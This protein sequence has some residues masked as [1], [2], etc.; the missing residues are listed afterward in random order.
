MRR[1][2]YCRRRDMRPDRGAQ[3]Q[4][5]RHRSEPVILVGQIEV[6]VQDEI[7]KIC[8]PAMLQ[9]HQQEGKII[10]DVDRG[11]CVREFEAIE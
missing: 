9:I 2:V 3:R 4:K 1:P 6:A 5:E 8:E 7:G 10:K 11:E